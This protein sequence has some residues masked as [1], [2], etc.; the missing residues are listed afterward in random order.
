MRAFAFLVLVSLPLA[1]ADFTTDVQPVLRKRCSGCHGAAMQ[2]NGFRVDHAASL[3]KGG[4]SGKAIEPGKAAESLLVKRVT[5]DKKEFQMPPAGPRL[6]AAEV[7]A[8]KAWIAA[9]AKIPADLLA[10]PL[11]RRQSDHWAF[12]PVKKPTVPVVAGAKTPIDAFVLARLQKEGIAPSPEASKATLLRRV[13]L[14][15][16]GLPPSDV[17]TREFM[18]DMRPD[19]YERLVDRLLASPHY[20]ER[21]ARH[22]LDLAHYADSD[23][24]EKDLTRPYAW[25][26]RDWVIRALN[27]NM[28]FDEFTIEQLAGD[29]MPNRTT[30]TEIATGFLR[31][32]LTNREAGVDRDEARFEQLVNRANTVSTTWLG[33]TTGC[34]QCHDHKYDPISQKDYYQLLSFFDRSDEEMIDAPVPG[35]MGPYLAALPEYKAKRAELMKKYDVAPLQAQWEEYMRKAISAPGSQAEYDFQLTSMKAMVDGAQKILLRPAAER[36]ERDKERLE[37]Y[38]VKNVGLAPGLDKAKMDSIK[39]MR[40]ELAELDK[41]L[42]R[43]AQAMVMVWDSESPRTRLRVKG[44]WN[45]PGIPVDADVP[46]VLPALG[47]SSADRLALARWMVRADNPM[48]PRVI[49]NRTWQEYFGRGLVRTSEDFGKMG[50]R[51]THPELLDWLA[52]EFR[53][54]GWD[55]KALHKTIVMSATYR[56]SSRARPELHERDPENALLARQQRMRLSAESIRDAALRVSGLLNTEIGGPSVKPPQPTG[57]EQLTYANNNKWVTSTGP[58]RYRRGLYIHFQRTAPY[59]M[60]MNFDSPDST[61]ACSRRTR[62][63]TSLQ[64]LNLMNDEVFYE[65]ANALAWRV[66]NEAPAGERAAYAAR[67][68][69]GREATDAEKARLSKLMDEMAGEKPLVAVCR[70]LLNTDEFIVRQ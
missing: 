14:D 12:Q 27:A 68:A 61:V 55:M 4:Y 58:E 22:W 1:A 26:Y 30:S 49:A 34:A 57:V 36:S 38:F 10:Q 44:Q 40:K 51:P 8:L 63:N 66:E 47:A 15:L 53:D 28:P 13:A 45:K 48:T 9:G 19:A 65:A 43:P 3:L 37:D 35:Q 6:T 25:Q 62:S 16:T 64:A 7:E 17:E 67:L 42:P 2:S 31:Q 24:Y 60:L 39:E 56:Q 21:W 50:E 54:S 11:P 52:A 20:G 33:M 18:A 46:G 5:S 69:W 41:A 70:A 32:V 29:M 59:P 23:G